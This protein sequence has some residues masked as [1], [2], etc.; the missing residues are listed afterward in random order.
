MIVALEPP[1]GFSILDP[2]ILIEKTP[3]GSLKRGSMLILEDM[4]M[5]F[6]GRVGPTRQGMQ[7]KMNPLT[8]GHT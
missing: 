3:L 2:E 6:L 7:I 5:S 1:E 4:G 8:S